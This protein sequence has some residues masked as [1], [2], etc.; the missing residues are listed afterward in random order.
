[1]VPDM[2]VIA[3]RVWGG[4]RRHAR[5]YVDLPRFK[6]GAHRN[7]LEKIALGELRVWI[8]P[9]RMIRLANCFLFF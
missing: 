4:T 6:E 9:P 3:K 7:E 8:S 2:N 5:R 1:M